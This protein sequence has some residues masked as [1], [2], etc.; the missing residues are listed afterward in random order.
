ML[1][2]KCNYCLY[3]TTILKKYLVLKL[4]T[5]EGDQIHD[6]LALTFDGTAIPVFTVAVIG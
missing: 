2:I 4:Y 5:Y 1:L 6:W 3:N